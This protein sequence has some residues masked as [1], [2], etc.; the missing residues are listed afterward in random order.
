MMC[1]SR[2]LSESLRCLETATVAFDRREK[3]VAVRCLL[4]APSPDSRRPQMI[5][6]E[7]TNCLMNRDSF[8][9][10]PSSLGG[11]AALPAQAHSVHSSSFPFV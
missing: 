5:Y 8:S 1:T 10:V 2:S 4:V 9:V 7:E 3:T 6:A 11:F